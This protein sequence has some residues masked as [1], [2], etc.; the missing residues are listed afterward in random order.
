MVN[1][2]NEMYIVFYYDFNTKEET[3]LKAFTTERAARMF[4]KKNSLEFF[5]KQQVLG[6]DILR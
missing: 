5:S 6:I 2:I 1:I 4:L 3:A